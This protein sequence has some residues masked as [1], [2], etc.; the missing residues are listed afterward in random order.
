MIACKT[1]EIYKKSLPSAQG[2]KQGLL[3]FAI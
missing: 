2:Q 1:G 3:S